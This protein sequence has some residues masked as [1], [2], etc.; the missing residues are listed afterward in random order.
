MARKARIEFEGAF[1]HVIVRGNQRQKIFKGKDDFM[2]Y[3]KI[4]STYKMRYRFFLY[5]YVLMSNHVHLLI[6]TQKTPLSK[7]LQG[8]NQSYTMYFNRKY[9]TVGHLFQGRYKAILCDRDEYLLALVKYIHDN[10]VRAKIAEIHDEYLW[11]SHLSYAQKVAVGQSIVDTEQI[12][13]MFSE[14]ITTA[15]KIYRAYMGDGVTIE[16]T[17][18]YRAVEQRILGNEKFVESIKDKSDAVI[19][20]KR[21]IRE[22]TLTEIAGVVEELYGISPKEMRA[23]SKAREISIGKRLM[24]LVAKEYGYKNKEIAEF[25]RKDPVVVSRHLKE[26]AHLEDEVEKI[27]NSLKDKRANVNK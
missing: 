15:R 17:D 3:I 22:H 7:I 12:L 26:K 23:M 10:P 16:K 19:S 14:D 1:Y 11:S 24:S 21:K 4:L 18:I 6:E 5:S 9:K 25:I 20:K 27:I 13:R 2:K 8:I